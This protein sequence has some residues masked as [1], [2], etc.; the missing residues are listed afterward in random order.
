[1]TLLPVAP[2]SS[3][4]ERRRRETARAIQLATVRL[5]CAHGLDHVTIEM[6]SAEAGISPRTFFN[7]YA[8]KEQAVW[9]DPPEFDPAAVAAFAHG[10]RPLMEDLEVLLVGHL[11]QLETDRDLF[12]GMRILAEQHP[13]LLVLKE[14]SLL[15]LR[16]KLTDILQQRLTE[17]DP[18]TLQLCALMLLDTIRLSIERWSCGETASIAVSVRD[19]LRRLRHG[20]AL[21]REDMGS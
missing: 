8:Y 16:V 20:A 5:G 19:M 6:I 11:A 4:R 17:E 3:L 21:F 10:T 2:S 18:A 15:D 9:C 12:A 13:K 7:Y 14:T 1:M